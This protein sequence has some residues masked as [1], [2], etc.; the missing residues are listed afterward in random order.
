M[1]IE[2][3]VYS[4]SLRS[5]VI[6]VF[7]V[8]LNFKYN[9][10]SAQVV[11]GKL[12]DASSKEPVKNVFV[13]LMPALDK[14]NRLQV[15]D[16]LGFFFF[17]Q[18]PYDRFY[19]KTDRVGYKDL[20]FGKL[21]IPQSDTLSLTINL[22]SVP[23]V[24]KEIPVLANKPNFDRELDIVGFYRRKKY[25]WGKFMT[26][27]DFKFRHVSQTIDLFRGIPG[28]MILG[29]RAYS[30]AGLTLGAAPMSVY[31]DGILVDDESPT[32]SA[33]N[34]ASPNTIKAI[35]VYSN[36]MFAPY[37]GVGTAVLF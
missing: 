22:E 4:S 29:N 16:S 20:T 21:S 17:D 37:Q 30:H 11:R 10:S 24:M 7:I 26:R 36:G 12:I 1:T 13:Y 28:V 23:F 18:V 15:S 19:I 3:T 25:G 6:F 5:T 34:V 14:L 35:E 32:F 9:S 33:L 8:I 27:D 31:I 2:R